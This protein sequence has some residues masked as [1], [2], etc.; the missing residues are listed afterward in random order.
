MRKPKCPWKPPFTFHPGNS[1]YY[2]HIQDSTGESV[3]VAKNSEEKEAIKAI[4]Y[5]LNLAY[6]KRR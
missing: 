2:P 6:K 4:C 3:R 5:A 1:F